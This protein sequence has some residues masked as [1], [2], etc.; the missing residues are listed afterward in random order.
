MNKERIYTKSSGSAD[1]VV[2]TVIRLVIGPVRSGLARNRDRTVKN[3]IGSVRSG[4]V[5]GLDFGPENR[6][7]KG[8]F[9]PVRSG[10]VGL[11]FIGLYRFGSLPVRV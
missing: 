8:R 4:L 9:G 7:D 2:H 3:L 10:L 5:I 6:S 11:F 1:F